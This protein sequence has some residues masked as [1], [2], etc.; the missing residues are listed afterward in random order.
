MSAPART[1]VS[2]YDYDRDLLEI[3]QQKTLCPTATRLLNLCH[4]AL[5]RT[6]DEKDRTALNGLIFALSTHR[7]MG[8][9]LPEKDARE[10]ESRLREGK[11]T[12]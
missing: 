7:R 2:E 5:D 12:A 4:D 3:Q 1:P 9:D 6:V 10:L 11:V 8:H